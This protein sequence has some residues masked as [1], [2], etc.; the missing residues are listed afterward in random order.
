[1]SALL[2]RVVLSVDLDRVI[3]RVTRGVFSGLD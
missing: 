3:G 2:I 1:M